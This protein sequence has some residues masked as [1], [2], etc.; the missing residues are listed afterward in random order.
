[1]D[2]SGSGH[3]LVASF[4]ECDDEPSCSGAVDLVS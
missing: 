2:L 4:S 1:V 3:G